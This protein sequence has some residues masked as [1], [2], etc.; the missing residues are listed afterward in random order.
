[1]NLVDP[2]QFEEINKHMPDIHKKAMDVKLDT[3]E[4][5]RKQQQEIYDIVKQFVKNKKRKI[6]GGFAV[7]ALVKAK[8]KKEAFYD[9]QTI[10][11]IEFYSPEPVKDLIELCNILFDKGIPYV[12]GA[13]AQHKETYTAFAQY[14]NFCDIS[15]VPRA[16]YNRIPFIELDGLMYTHPKFI[17][18]D[19]YRI[20]NNPV[21]SSRVFEKT[22]PRFYVLQKNYPL[23]KYTEKIKLQNIIKPLDKERSKALELV[24]EHIAT[25]KTGIL[26]GLPLYNFFMKQVKHLPKY[27]N[28][29]E[30]SYYQFITDNLRGDG[31]ELYDSLKK[32]YPKEISVKEFYPFFQFT[33][34]K[35]VIYFNDIKLVEIY[36]HNHNCIP[37]IDGKIDNTQVRFVTFDFNLMMTMIAKT[38]EHVN[39]DT[40][41][42]II[43]NVMISHL[44]EIREIYFKENNKN[45]LS[46]TVFQ[47]FIVNCLGKTMDPGRAARL[48]MD[49]KVKK[50]KGPYKYYYRPHQK[51]LDPDS[52]HFVFMNTSGNE[53]RYEKN[54][55][56]MTNKNNLS[57]STSES[58]E[59]EDLYADQ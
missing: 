38:Y 59:D 57:R 43:Y 2:K 48:E 20:F 52:S 53:V 40:N 49:E 58:D 6:Y 19:H 11:D 31:Q 36:G 13:E 55:R 24:L 42:K 51:R 47:S 4:P 3:L 9:D 22:F 46:N 5:T 30:V 34:R 44:L 28:K 16:I 56:I 29:L 27:I 39:K 8:N 37:F 17:Y 1:M 41:K 10:N 25:T 21:T 32:L 54:F 23:P 7:N 15:Y 18:I 14:V 26:F 33:D 12:S 35:A 45:Q 50:K